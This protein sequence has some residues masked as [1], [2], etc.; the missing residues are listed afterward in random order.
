MALRSAALVCLVLGMCRWRWSFAAPKAEVSKAQKRKRYA[1]RSTEERLLW[2]LGCELWRAGRDMALASGSV[3]RGEISAIFAEEEEIGSATSSHLP[4]VL[5]HGGE[6]LQEAGGAL[7]DGRWRLAWQRLERA[8][9]TGQEYWPCQGLNGLVDLVFSMAEMPSM[10]SALRTWGAAQSLEHLAEGLDSAIDAIDHNFQIQYPHRE[11][12][13]AL[14]VTA[15][16]TL[17]D[18]AV[19]FDGGDFFLP[20][21]PRKVGMHFHDDDGDFWEEDDLGDVSDPLEYISG[22]LAATL[23][24]RNIQKELIRDSDGP[25][26]RKKLL[27]RLVRENHPDQNPGKEEE[28]RPAFEYCLRMLRLCKES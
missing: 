18:A 27:H 2:A 11:R 19:I 13:E 8:Q 4:T 16:E 9:G 1:P 12:A 5:Q 25:E 26:S 14:L 7:L 10:P 21:D 28:V 24:I 17:R 6:A 23:R 15:T 22:D 3:S 20:R